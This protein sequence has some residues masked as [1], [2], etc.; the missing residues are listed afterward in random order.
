MSQIQNP[1]P[2]E[3]EVLSEFEGTWFLGAKVSDL[4]LNVPVMTKQD[5]KAQACRN[6]K[7]QS[8]YASNPIFSVLCKFQRDKVKV[9]F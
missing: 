6:V 3:V 7:I 4:L 1:V 8:P 5:V 2:L 9:Y